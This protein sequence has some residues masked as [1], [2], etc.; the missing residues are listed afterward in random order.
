MQGHANTLPL[1]RRMRRCLND[2]PFSPSFVKQTLVQSPRTPEAQAQV[3]YD[4]QPDALLA[5]ASLEAMGRASGPHKGVD[6]EAMQQRRP[7][8]GCMIAI[9]TTMKQ[10]AIG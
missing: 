10:L 4:P 2:C 1:P 6:R 5:Q 7:R 8:A 9:R 3:L